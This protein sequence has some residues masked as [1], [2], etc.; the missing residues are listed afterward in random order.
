MCDPFLIPFMEGTV[1]LV[2]RVHGLGR[3]HLCFNRDEVVLKG[4]AEIIP[5]AKI[6]VGESKRSLLS[7]SG[8]FTSRSAKFEVGQSTSNVSAFGAEDILV[9]EIV[10]FKGGPK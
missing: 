9:E 7:V 2:K 10:G 1:V 4:G 3:R 8:P 5:T 6:R